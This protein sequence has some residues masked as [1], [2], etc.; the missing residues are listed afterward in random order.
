MYVSL[1]FQEQELSGI[2]VLLEI[3]DVPGN[4]MVFSIHWMML[5]VYTYHKLGK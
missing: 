2:F 3:K 1:D 4:Q 5:I